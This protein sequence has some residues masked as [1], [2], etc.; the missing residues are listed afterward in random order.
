M[1]KKK[2]MKNEM[3]SNIRHK[4]EHSKGQGARRTTYW[5]AYQNKL[6]NMFRK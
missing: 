4:F 6:N 5:N 2:A 3:Q 1:E